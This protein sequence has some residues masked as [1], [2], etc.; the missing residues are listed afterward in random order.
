MLTG[1]KGE[2][3]EI[4]T[5]LKLLSEGKLYAADSNLN[6]IED[7][8]YPIIKILRSE[9]SGSL[10]Y[11]T[12]CKI[13]VIDAGSELTLLEIPVEDFKEKSI[14]LLHNIKAAK[15]SSF[16]VPEIEDFMHSIKCTSLKAPSTDKSDIKIMVHDLN[17]GFNPILGFSI[18]SKLGHPST[19]LNPGKTTNFIYK[20]ICNDSNEQIDIINNIDGDAK[21]KDRMAKIKKCGYT[22]EFQGMENQTFK[23]NLQVIDT[24]L[25]Y[26]LSQML[27]YFYDG[28]EVSLEGLTQKLDK[29]N[30]CQY[31][32]SEK[33]P[34][35]RYKIKKLLTEIALGMTPAKVWDGKADATGG[36]IVVREDGEVLCYHIY[37]RNDFEEYLLK[38]TKFE[39]P[40]TSRYDFGY[41][42]EVEGIK[43]IK[44]NLQIRFK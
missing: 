18:K 23:N 31:N 16:S 11:H 34:F 12:N 28:A 17:T 29:V 44:L 36:Y 39:T 22:L 32:F 21:I 2:W 25:P 5:F 37:N 24:S 10:E 33:H 9:S 19:L 15:G 27:L 42:F 35:Y 3:S 20:V 38:N 1:N 40:S 30:P 7:I 41:I 6:K 4:Y 14:T 26:I 43:Y 13:R 8:Y